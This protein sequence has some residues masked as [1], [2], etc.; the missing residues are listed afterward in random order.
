MIRNSRGQFIKG[1]PVL[2]KNLGKGNKLWM[3]AK[4]PELMKKLSKKFTGK[5]NPFYG[6][7][8]SEETRL[9]MGLAKFGKKGKLS[10]AWKNGNSNEINLLR[11]SLEYSIWR[12]AIYKKDNWTCRICERHCQRKNIVAHHLNSFSEFSELRFSINN[13]MTLCRKCHGEI[14]NPQRFL[15]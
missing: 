14:H 5:G 15:S 4:T 1:H 11:H 7:K 9:K 10:N 13:G 12:Q 6:K 3:L 8:H 2:S